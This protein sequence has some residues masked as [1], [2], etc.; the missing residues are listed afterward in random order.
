MKY[1]SGS[2][3]FLVAVVTAL[4]TTLLAG[5]GAGSGTGTDAAGGVA[6]AS[7]PQPP[8]LAST[9]GLLM[10][11]SGMAYRMYQAAFDRAPD[12]GGLDFYIDQLATGRMSLKAMAVGFIN[13]P[14]FKS[15]Y[16]NGVSNAAFVQLLYQ[17]VLGRAPDAAGQ[18]FHQGNLDAG[19][20]D[21]ADTLVSF[22]ESPE[23]IARVN[24]KTGSTGFPVM[25]AAHMYSN[26]GDNV[27]IVKPA[28]TDEPQALRADSVATESFR[29]TYTDGGRAI[30]NDIAVVRLTGVTVGGTRHASAVFT[31][32]R[33][34]DTGELSLSLRP[35]QDAA[36]S[37]IA[38]FGGDVN[39]SVSADGQRAY[40]WELVKVRA[41]A[42]ELIA[43]VVA[44]ADTLVA[45]GSFSTAPGAGFDKASLVQA[46]AQFRAGIQ[47]DDNAYF[48]YL[49]DKN[50]NW[51]ALT[52]PVFYGDLSDPRA[53]LK[54]RPLGN[55]DSGASF[56]FDDEDLSYFLA[57]AR[58]AGFKIM[59][60]LELSPVHMNV[61]PGEPNCRTINH[62]PNR[63]LL[64]QPTVAASDPMQACIEPSLWWWSPA[65]PDHARNTA[66]FWQT[67]TEVAVKYAKLAQAAGVEMYAFATEQDNLVRTRAGKAPYT[68]HFKPQLQTLIGAIRA[69]YKGLLTYDQQHQTMSDAH[70]FAGGAGT[71][72]AFAG[73]FEDL[74]LDVVGTSAYFQLTPTP[75]TRVMS[76]AEFET[77]WQDIFTRHL[78][79]RQAANPG[80]PLVFTEFG[81]TDDI[82]SPAL[83]GAALGTP[84]PASAGVSPG[85][86]QQQNIFQAFFN[87]NARN[88]Y[89]IRGAFI[90]GV[91]AISDYDCNNIVFGIYCKASAETVKKTYGDWKAVP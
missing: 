3:W 66:A 19:R 89:L 82:A 30:T 41:A 88:N 27:R 20:L 22:S 21:F 61:T 81:Y 11:H 80:K 56:T 51:L 24:D 28:L 4:M 38:G 46:M 25:R 71:S 35:S 37:A 49:R 45:A 87:V 36:L 75:P 42:R 13:S 62:K 78:I 15:R 53:Y 34:T 17:N 76:V 29:S 39:I 65:H 86:Q 83:Q 23:N 54:Y 58:K 48:N 69:N 68:N 18:A 47:R 60:G 16:G 59:L 40:Q 7:A 84:E 32:G 33:R 12:Q 64:G 85:Q 73:V 63:W 8:M 91:S 6:P 9:P 50:I 55:I 26:Y 72:E 14:E 31:F 43:A 74:G 1:R 67:Y 77:I 10:G 44:H 5:C 79:P 90:W 2:P 52:V 57:K 70:M